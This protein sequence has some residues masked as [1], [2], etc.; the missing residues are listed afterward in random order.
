MNFNE[1]TDEVVALLKEK[2]GSTCTVTVTEVLKNN[3]VRLTGI[4]IKE[5]TCSIAPTVY[6]EGPY[7]RYQEGISLEVIAEEIRDEYEKYAHNLDRK[8]VV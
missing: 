8:S 5:E 4:V 2:M 7:K 3:N 6:L 1:F